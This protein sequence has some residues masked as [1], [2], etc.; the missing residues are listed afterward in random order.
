VR[1]L[2]DVS[3]LAGDGFYGAAWLLCDNIA[4]TDNTCVVGA[5]GFSFYGVGGTSAASPAFAGIMA[6]VEQSQS[7][8]SKGHVRLGQ[9][10]FVLYNLANQASVYSSAFHDVPIGSNNSVYCVSGSPNCGPNLFETGYNTG[11]AYDLATGL[12]SVDATQLI[13]DWTK[14]A[15]TATTTAFTINGATTPISITHGQTVTLNATVAGGATLP[16]GDVALISN[17][18]QDADT[19]NSNGL[20]FFPLANGT[21]GSVSYSNLPGGT[22]TVYANYGGDINF[23]QSQ[24]TGVQVNVAKENSVL[25]LSNFDSSG[26]QISVAGSYPYGSFFSTEAEPV[27]VSQENSSTPASATGSVVFSDTAGFPSGVSGTAPI[28]SNGYAELP[29]YYF[30]PGA[31][32]VSA[33]YAGDNS[34]NASTGGP[35]TFAIAQAPTANTVTPS[36]TTVSSGTFTV[37]S[38]ITPTPASGA[39][40]PTGTVTLTT[41]GT[42]IGTG[43]VAATQDSTTGASLGTVSITVNVTS[44]AAG[45]NTITAAYSGDT[46]Y[47]ASSA[48]TTVTSTATPVTPSIAVTA[49]AATVSS[50][51]QSGSST[52]T[53]TPSNYT[54][55]VNLTCAPA[56]SPSGANATYNP[57]CSLAS[58]A[59][60]ITS[61][62]ATTTATFTTTAPTSG[63]LAYPQTNRKNRLYEA[64]GG[65]ALACILFFGIP[66]RRRGWRSML[67]L[68][69]FLVTMAGVGCGGGGNNNNGT[70]GTT[71][72]VYTFTVTGTD[73]VTA[74]LKSAT[75][76]TLTVQ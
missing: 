49:T 17:A 26:N 31:H 66:A 21:T 11:T 18:N 15:F 19:Y 14:A 59:V 27:G 52:V 22:Y 62:A 69:S 65:A 7:A 72:G 12:G 6:L 40:S 70:P 23:A 53:I 38:I 56:T 28:N 45:A 47:A 24:S 41:N 61:G 44:L 5:T 3:L 48:T 37:T 10:N 16:T 46:N 50:P 75:T 64:E 42:T 9:A 63:A 76:I 4:S 39:A 68:L 54:G 71:T 67:T 34:L 2:P 20:G 74:T 29:L 51:G 60:K 43:T 1:D 8:G 13:D 55:T 57:A 32:S 35:I 73:S 33:S 25:G 58:S 30:S 36:A